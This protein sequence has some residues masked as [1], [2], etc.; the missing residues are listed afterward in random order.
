M[1]ERELKT[2]VTPIT[3][4]DGAGAWNKPYMRSYVGGGT[5]VFVPIQG[6]YHVASGLFDTCLVICEEKMSTARPHPQAVF[7]N[8]FDQITERPLGPN[9][10]W[11]FALEMNRYMSAYGLDKRDIDLYRT[12]FYQGGHVG[13]RDG[14]VVG[15][16]L[17]YGAARVVSDKKRVETEVALE[18]WIG[19]WRYAE[20]IDMDDLRI[21][22]GLGVGFNVVDHRIDE[23]LGLA[24]ARADEDPVARVDMAEDD[25]PRTKL[26][27]EPLREIAQPGVEIS[28]VHVFAD[29]N[30]GTRATP[31]VDARGGVPAVGR[32]APLT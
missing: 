10:L 18:F 28:R 12:V 17:V 5:G 26:L 14:G 31:R 23:I 8:I 15:Q 4:S 19:I 22:K 32:R 20:G 30:T 27:R 1:A 25:R 2:V 3:V 9:L 29:D 24:A 13:K 21:K 11:I 6:W 7:I 16:P